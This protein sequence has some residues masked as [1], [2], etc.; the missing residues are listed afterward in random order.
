MK[1]K[2][3]KNRGGDSYYQ[4]KVR[5]PDNTWNRR[6]VKWVELRWASDSWWEWEAAGWLSRPRSWLLCFFL[7]LV[8]PTST[9]LS[10]FSLPGKFTRSTPLYPD[11]NIAYAE[12]SLIASSAS[13]HLAA[14]SP[15]KKW[16]DLIIF[17]LS[18][19]CHVTL[20]S[21]LFFI[22]CSTLPH[23]SI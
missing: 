5:K 14:L 12:S 17:N 15:L 8:I 20:L 9:S 22:S 1:D 16:L 4:R 11:R 21:T 23:Y 10:S 2:Q 3:R 6:R 13:P 7:S 18:N 19:G